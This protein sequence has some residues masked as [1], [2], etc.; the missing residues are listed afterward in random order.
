[1]AVSRASAQRNHQLRPGAAG[2]TG[3]IGV[4]AGGV[5]RARAAGPSPAISPLGFVGKDSPFFDDGPFRRWFELG[6]GR[7]HR[8]PLARHKNHKRRLPGGFITPHIGQRTPLPMAMPRRIHC[9][10]DPRLDWLLRNLDSE[11]SVTRWAIRPNEHAQRRRKDAQRHAQQNS[12]QC[13]PWPHANNRF[14]RRPQPIY[15]PK[16]ASSIEAVWPNKTIMAVIRNTQLHQGQN[17]RCG[18]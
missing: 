5:G 4:G 9:K 11:S 8:Q 2:C 7:R 15:P 6:A 1:L 10:T 12:T 3:V 14:T 17:R 18:P 13:R 16:E